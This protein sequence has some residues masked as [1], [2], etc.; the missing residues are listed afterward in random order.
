MSGSPTLP[1]SI[2]KACDLSVD[3]LPHV[4]PVTMVV[5]ARV[6]VK[7]EHNNSLSGRSAFGQTPTYRSGVRDA[8]PRYACGQDQVSPWSWPNAHRGLVNTDSPR[9]GDTKPDLQLLS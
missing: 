6:V 2:G 7:D 5:G 9:S 1:F 4:A 3:R 8:R